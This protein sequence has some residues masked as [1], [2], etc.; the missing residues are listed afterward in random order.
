MPRIYRR[1]KELWL[2]GF[3]W[4]LDWVYASFWQIKGALIPANFARYKRGDPKKPAIILLPGVYERW[5]FLQPLADLL[6]EK[7]YR[8]HIIECLGY[9]R[10][11]VESAAELVM[12]YIA[13]HEIDKYIFV[14]HSKGGLIGKYVMMHSI[15]SGCLGMVAINTPFSGSKLARFM[16]YKTLRVFSPLAPVVKTLRLDSHV[17]GKIISIYSQF[18]PHIIEGSYLEGARR[19]LRL[20]VRG[21]I[22]I[23]ASPQVKRRVLEA[24]QEIGSLN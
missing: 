14:A 19:N 13:K 10:S 2:D 21:H 11:T 3:H 7:N 24:V 20:P 8:L 9:N 1:I 6:D 12:E 17:N 16:P 15:D 22:K 18:D 23:L 5:D 4:W